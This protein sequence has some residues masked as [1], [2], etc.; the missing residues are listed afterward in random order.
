M[1]TS[2]RI[3]GTLAIPVIA[4][5]ILEALCLSHG[6]NIITNAKSFDNFVIYAA[7]VMITSNATNPSPPA[8]FSVSTATA[9][10]E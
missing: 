8:M 5:I 10:S 2:K 9:V 4:S 3:I 1:S 6:Q 7:I